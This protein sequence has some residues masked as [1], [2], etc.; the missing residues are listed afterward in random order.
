MK[1]EKTFQNSFT[2]S[3]SYSSYT[4]NIE[5]IY[6]YAQHNDVFIVT[7]F[8]DTEGNLKLEAIGFRYETLEFDR[9]L[10]IEA[11]IATGSTIQVPI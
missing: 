10:K 6:V 4:M 5:C 2:L 3:A 9:N 1:L 8:T 11:V 7:S